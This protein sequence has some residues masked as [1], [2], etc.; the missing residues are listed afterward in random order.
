M[1]NNKLW[2]LFII[3]FVLIMLNKSV[4][5]DYMNMTGGVYSGSFALGMGIGGFNLKGG[6]YTSNMTLGEIISGANYTGGL[7]GGELG[8]VSGLLNLPPIVNSV[9]ISPSNP[10]VNNTLNCTVSAIDNEGS[11]LTIYR[12]WYNV[13][14]TATILNQ[15]KN[16]EVINNI[17][18][19]ESYYCRA[20]AFDGSENS[21]QWVVSGTVY[22]N[23]TIYPVI[24]NAQSISSAT[25]GDT[26]NFD[27]DCMDGGSNVQS[28]VVELRDPSNAIANNSATFLSG[29]TYR[30]SVVL[31]SLGNYTFKSVT[32]IDNNNLTTLNAS[33]NRNVEV[34]V[35]PVTPPSSGTTGGGG[36]GGGSRQT[37]LVIKAISSTAG[38]WTLSTQ[39]GAT[40]YILTVAN[41]D[42]LK[43]RAPLIID[44][45][46]NTILDFTVECN[47]L[48]STDTEHSKPCD[49][50]TFDDTEFR[51]VPSETKTI[52]VQFESTN[53]PDNS[54]Y[55]FEIIVTDNSN[56]SLPIK[57]SITVDYII[58]SATKFL[59]NAL[60]LIGL[61]GL[62]IGLFL[63]GV[64]YFATSKVNHANRILASF[65]TG[66]ISTIFFIIILA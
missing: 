14:G 57:Y 54:L 49:Y 4:N 30:R 61:Y 3:F 58:G 62:L 2:I 46:G 64:V 24:S 45:I 10:Q 31:G 25:Q 23:D 29:I 32:C 50:V 6:S 38:N 18:L 16:Y 63:G 43:N 39:G 48:G 51:L 21:T 44:N 33:I 12:D 55:T 59:R 15:F 37:A 5:A 42:T 7:Y 53:F 13:T 9:S 17:S 60:T 26:V 35:A 27:I 22:V 1:L 11:T 36:G 28:V 8:Y 40:E 56:Y 20:K 66:I 65:F 34:T 19:S 47:N 41:T 52:D